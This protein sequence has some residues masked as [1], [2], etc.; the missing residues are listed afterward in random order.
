VK[1]NWNIGN[2]VD[3][4]DRSRIGKRSEDKQEGRLTPGIL[5]SLCHQISQA[6]TMSQIVPG[7]GDQATNAKGGVLL[8]IATH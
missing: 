3:F 7:K 8:F 2:D 4:R 6:Q 1:I 5:P